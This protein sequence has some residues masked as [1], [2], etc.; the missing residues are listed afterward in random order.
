MKPFSERMGLYEKVPIQMDI[1]NDDLRV[2][3]WNVLHKFFWSDLKNYRFTEESQRF[4]AFIYY[5]WQ[6]F[7][8]K[9]IDDIPPITDNYV[10][11]VRKFFFE[12]DWSEVY[13]IIEIMSAYGG[14][15][16]T[17]RCNAALE[18]ENAGYRFVSTK[19]SPIT[20]PEEISEIEQSIN[21]PITSVA[22]HL[23]NALKLLS[24]KAA[25][26]YRN[27]I[28]ESISAVEAICKLI[29]QKPDATL[30]QALNVLERQ[31]KIVLHPSL[32]SAFHKLYGYTSD[33][34]GIRHSLKD[35][36]K[37]TAGYDEA[38]FMMVAC[39]AFVN[40]MSSKASN[41]GIKL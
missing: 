29:T 16:F 5:L 39:S 12:C 14:D 32:L 33:G 8:K 34:A 13:D 1:V 11:Y 41:A 15:E 20:N 18:K 10:K 19:I 23:K 36:D 28:K 27:S 38:K 7:F 6:D 4:H 26:D 25:P 37:A 3:L 30:G 31:S 2:Q 17:K 9:P 35:D 22:T 40:Y 24:D 21:S